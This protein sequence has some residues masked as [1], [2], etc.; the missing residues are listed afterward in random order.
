M[1]YVGFEYVGQFEYVTV[2][3]ASWSEGVNDVLDPVDEQVAHKKKCIDKFH[4][5]C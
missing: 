5:G 2:K 3:C 1:V 4:L